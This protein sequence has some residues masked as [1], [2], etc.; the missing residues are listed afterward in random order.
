MKTPDEIKKGLEC[1]TTC[2][3]EDCNVC[4]YKTN[5]CKC[6]ST[7]TGDALAYIRELETN[8]HQLLTKVEQLEAH[9]PRWRRNDG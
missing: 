2:K 8:S 7:L 9:A 1:C 4:A 5:D 6:V 3:P